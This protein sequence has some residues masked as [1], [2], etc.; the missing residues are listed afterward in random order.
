MKLTSHFSITTVL[1][2][3]IITSETLIKVK[4]NSKGLTSERI[5]QEAVAYG[6]RDSGDY[7]Y[8]NRDDSGQWVW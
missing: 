7:N 1:K 5:T 8:D 3:S 6:R 2:Q 4:N